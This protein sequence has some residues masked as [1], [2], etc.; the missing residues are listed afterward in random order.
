MNQGLIS[1]SRISGLASG[2]SR[3]WA[4]R[5]VGVVAALAVAAFAVTALL[6][7]PTEFG[8]IALN[9]LTLGG[10]YFL[11]AS[12]FSL[13]FGVMRVVNLAHGSF[14]L[15]GG[16]IGSVVV[17]ATGSW[18]LAA[19]AGAVS[20]L[21]FGVVLQQTL[22]RRV[23]GD[24]MREALVT[25]GVSVIVA[26]LMLAAWGGSITSIEQPSWTMGIAELPLDISYPLYR[27][28]V[29]GLAVVAAA[30]LWYLLQRTRTGM[31][32]RASVDDR[33]MVAA[34]G[35]NVEWVFAGVF[36]LGALLAGLS[37][38]A[39]GTFIALGPG[40]DQELLLVSLIVVIIGGLGSLSGTVISAAVVG[41]VDQFAAVY[42]P[43]YSVLYV[44]VVLV[45]V[46]AFRPQGLFGRVS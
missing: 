34:L 28:F 44:F 10:L 27:L 40:Q 31:I 7:A 24:D 4:V 8:F 43:E 5:G 41:L 26:D 11:V 23:Q 25:I 46:L 22:L 1:R 17:V 42:H 16:Y 38:V 14:Y 36:A 29:L 12:G 39:G 18:L 21:L 20:I 33:R 15:L 37:G 2:N 19:L 35:I 45:V 30:F 32:M 9:G 3:R 6:D 13:I